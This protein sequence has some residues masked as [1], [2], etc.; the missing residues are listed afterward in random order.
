MTQLMLPRSVRT[1]EVDPGTEGHSDDRRVG[2]QRRAY[3]LVTAVIG[4]GLLASITPTPLY[5]TYARLWQFST[6]TLTLVYA[7]YAFGV[8]TTLLL[9]G[10]ASDVVGRR[11]VLLA[12][13]G[14]LG[15]STVL[16]MLADSVAWLFVARG[17]QGLATGAALSTASASMLDFHPRRDA[18]RVAH[19]NGIVSSGGVVIG[20]L[21]SSA[22]VEAGW[23]PRVLPYVFV[24]ALLA[25]AFAGAVYL[26]EPV[27]QRARFRLTPQ[28]PSVPAAVGGPFVLA[29]LAVLSSWTLAGL[30]FTLG[31]PL[32]GVIFHSANV[33]VSSLGIVMVA[34]MGTISV[35]PLRRVAPWVN[36]SVG[37]VALAAGMVLIVLAAAWDSVG[38]FI[39]GSIL[40]GAGFGMAFF[41]GL[42]GLVVVIPPAH[43]GAGFGRFLHHR[44]RVDISA[45]SA[46][47]HCRRA[48]GPG[49][50]LRD[51]RQ[52]RGRHRPPGDRAVMAHSTPGAAT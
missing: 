31:P 47:R 32:A 29:A 2:Y 4:L 33:V 20:A 41:G 14:V 13:L 51:L 17:L 5:E 50:H 6:P 15:V 24:L 12:A 7:T 52:R 36:A 34:G 21:V 39:G 3:V 23:A 28:R 19:L 9:A 37:S 35:L 18:A 43:R 44:L 42:R 49:T 16:Y 40:A 46:R 38:Y 27:T 48:P 1:A 22:L 10:G 25:V 11:P 26:P 8:L 30:Y 45:S